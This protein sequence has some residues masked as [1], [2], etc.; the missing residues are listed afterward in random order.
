MVQDGDRKGGWEGGREMT[1]V[2]SSEE[3]NGRRKTG[4]RGVNKERHQDRE[5]DSRSVEVT[6]AA[7]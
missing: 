7:I 1:W 6:A 2:E 5:G 3:R 4:G